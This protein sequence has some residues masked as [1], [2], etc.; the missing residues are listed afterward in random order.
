[1]DWIKLADLGTFPHEK[2]AQVLEAI[3]AQAMV[4][5]FHS[6]KG[7]WMRKFL[8]LPIFIGHPDD[9]DAL[10][11]HRKVYGRIQDLKQE[12]DA[13]WMLVKWTDIGHE[14]YHHHMLK[15]FSPRWLT[16]I[17]EH[18]QLSPRR[19]LSVGLTNYPNIP[20]Q[21]TTIP[22]EIENHETIQAAPLSQDAAQDNMKINEINVC[23][24][25][26][27]KDENLCENPTII[28]EEYNE[29]FEQKLLLPE[30][31]MTEHLN[32]RLSEKPKGEKILQLVFD[33]MQQSSESYTDAWNTI[34][35]LYPNLF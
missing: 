24:L 7:R 22:V 31:S 9:R 34:R 6:L 17:N 23:K 2:G 20:C 4:D 18:G 15:S 14:L 3:S 11:H 30:T 33:R 35:R 25:N 26:E 29:N 27:I 13:L 16:Y 8:G 5:Y 21:H 19:L 32:T 10:H 28:K 1:M 12:Q